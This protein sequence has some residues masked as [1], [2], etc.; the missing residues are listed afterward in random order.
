MN[1]SALLR[2]HFGEQGRRSSS[3]ISFKTNFDSSSEN[4]VKTDCWVSRSRYAMASAARFGWIEPEHL[5]SLWSGQ[6]IRKLGEVGGR[7]SD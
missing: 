5:N 1:R 6:R 4:V 2:R 7:A 3:A